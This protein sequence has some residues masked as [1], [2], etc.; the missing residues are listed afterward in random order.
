MSRRGGTEGGDGERRGS[1]G[2]KLDDVTDS[3]EFQI[4]I[5][6][7]QPCKLNKMENPYEP[8][9][10][11]LLQYNYQSYMHVMQLVT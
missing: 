10:V 3:H 6:K 5:G 1:V 8:D 2:K 4:N 9:C 7:A 11:H